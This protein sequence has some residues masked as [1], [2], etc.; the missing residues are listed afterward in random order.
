MTS[1]PNMR[2]SQAGWRW[3]EAKSLLLLQGLGLLGI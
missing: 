3:G 1:G 2:C